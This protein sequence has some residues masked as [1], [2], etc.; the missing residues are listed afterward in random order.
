M[1]EIQ[2]RVLKV[3]A[4]YDKVTSDKVNIHVFFHASC[5]FQNITDPRVKQVRQYSAKPPL[6]LNFIRDRVLLVLKLYDKIDPTKV[7]TYLK[8]E[9]VS[10][11]IFTI[12]YKLLYSSLLSF[13]CSY[14]SFNH[15]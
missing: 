5:I 6:T 2:D 11:D 10:K 7:Y 1:K 8:L 13:V 15:I 9:D 14:Y 4:A 12:L 3:V